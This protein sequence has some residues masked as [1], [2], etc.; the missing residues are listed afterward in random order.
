MVTSPGGTTIAAIRELEMAGVR[1]AFLNAIQAAMVR[2]ARARG[3][4]ALAPAGGRS[5][6][7]ARSSIQR[8]GRERLEREHGV[9]DRD[10]LEDTPRAPRSRRRSARIA[11]SYAARVARPR[12]QRRGRHG[13]RNRRVPARVST[14]ARRPRRPHRARA[15]RA[16]LRS[17][18][19]GLSDS[20]A[21]IERPQRV[22]V[23]AVEVA[24]D[25][26]RLH[27]ADRPAPA[28]GGAS[29]QLSR[30]VSAARTSHRAASSRRPSI[31]ERQPRR[32]R[33][34]A[35]PRELALALV[36]VLG[37]AARPRPRSAPLAACHPFLP[38]DHR[39][40]EVS[41]AGAR[42]SARWSTS[43]AFARRSAARAPDG[44]SED[45]RRRHG[46]QGR[47]RAP[48][49]QR[50]A[51][52][53]AIDDVVFAATAQVGDQGLTLDATSHCS[54]ACPTTVPGSQSTGCA[55]AR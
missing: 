34:I 7:R 29:G 5:A 24:R 35:H 21:R 3:R 47:A 50:A 2:V 18:R 49:P 15:A 43:T 12:A 52:A 13:L 17:G 6:S 38:V 25:Q 16:R 31:S 27:R 54:P 30:Y 33:R 55:R 1:A 19:S 10:V 28:P 37:A 46:R 8:V 26:P 48:P 20:A 4:R 39:L 44:S 40:R 9:G 36:A 51:P 42:S 41:S 45:A 14:R 23:S 11:A 22:R 53:G 32:P